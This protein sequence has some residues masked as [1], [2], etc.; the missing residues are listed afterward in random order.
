MMCF[1]YY[2]QDL[3]QAALSYIVLLASGFWVFR[4]GGATSCTDQGEIWQGGADLR[5]S[6][7]NFTLTGSGMG[8]TAPKT[9]KFGIL[10]I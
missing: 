4:P 7:P 10:P 6:L 5:Y 3:P 9:E 8:F 2:R 1:T